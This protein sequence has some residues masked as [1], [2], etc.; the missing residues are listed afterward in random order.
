MADLPGRARSP[1]ITL[2][3]RPTQLHSALDQTVLA[4]RRLAVVLYLPRGRLPHIDVGETPQMGRL[5]FISLAHDAPPCPWAL[6]GPGPLCRS[7]GRAAPAGGF[8]RGGRSAPRS[9]LGFR[10]PAVPRP[11]ARPSTTV[12]IHFRCPLPFACSPARRRRFQAKHLSASATEASSRRRRCRAESWGAVK[13]GASSSRGQS[14]QDAGI[15]ERVPSGSASSNCGL[16]SGTWCQ[17]L[18]RNGPAA[19]DARGLWSPKMGGCEVGSIW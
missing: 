6:P 10:L 2:S 15:S 12:V 13:E 9:P 16:P 8:G 7:L 11:P 3:A 1:S 18:L 5:D 17:G 19:D 4:L 14:V